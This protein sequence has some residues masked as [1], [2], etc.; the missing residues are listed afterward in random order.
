[1]AKPRSFASFSS[2]VFAMPGALGTGIIIHTA[3]PLSAARRQALLA[4]VERYERVL[5]RFRAD[6]LVAR[7]ARRGAGDYEFPAWAA[8]LFHIC[9]VMG[10][11]TGGRFD[12]CVGADLVR[13]GYGPAWGA[14]DL[15]TA[16]SGGVRTARWGRTVTHDGAT[17]HVET[18]ALC[19]FG[20]VGKGFLVDLLARYLLGGDDG[21][22]VLHHSSG[23][24]DEADG[25]AIGSDPPTEMCADHNA[26][27]GADGLVIDAGGDLFS[28]VPLT[29]ALESPWDSS[30]AV[31][32]ARI[33]SGAFCASS[34]SRRHWTDARTLAEAH[35]LL[36]AATGRP[37]HDVAASWTYAPLDSTPYPTAWAD[38][39]CTALFCGLDHGFP[40]ARLMSD[41]T[42]ALSPAFPGRFFTA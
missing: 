24:G 25:D 11:A 5:S 1:M 27:P 15:L 19:D 29:I 16:G 14:G 40:F 4:F 23:R 20:A 17:L 26:A 35:H 13:L 33:P 2:T 8:E 36:D 3:A 31:G 39:Q 34:P 42:A 12:P 7:I 18:P 22:V 41:G 9:D 32:E 6:S 28:T 37:V 38:A 30:Q 10:E 21:N